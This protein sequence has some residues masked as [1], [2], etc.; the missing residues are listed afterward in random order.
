MF[1]SGSNLVLAEN[2]PPKCFSI[3]M[4]NAGREGEAVKIGR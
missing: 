3:K 2:F 1:G 4:V